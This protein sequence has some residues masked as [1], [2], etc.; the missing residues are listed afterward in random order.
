[1]SQ[2]VSAIFDIGKT[3]KKFFLFN[4]DFQVVLEESRLLPE[5]VDEDGES[6]EDLNTLLQWIMTT[7]NNALQLN[8]YNI[9]A[10][11]FSCYGASLIHLNGNAEPITP[12]YSYQKEMDEALLQQFYHN[13]GSKV[14]LWK[15]TG[16]D[17]SGFLNSGLQLY[18]LKHTKSNLF[19]KI[20]LSIHL[21]QYL[22][23]LFSGTAITE[24]TSLGCHTAMWDYQKQDYHAW[25]YEEDLVRL[26]P[27]ILDKHKAF[28]LEAENR[29]IKI[30]CGIHDSSAALL[31]YIL[32]QKKPFCLISTGT[33]SVS[34]N[35]FAD[36]MLTD[37]DINRNCIFYMQGDGKAVKSSRFMLGAEHDFQVKIL[38]EQYSV[39]AKSYQQL[40]F[41]S[42]VFDGVPK[43]DGCPFEWKYI[44]QTK[45]PPA[46]TFNSF[47]EAYHS[48]V[49]HLVRAQ[50]ESL[51]TLLESSDVSDIIVEGGFSSNQIFL[52]TLAECLSEHRIFSSQSRA[53]AALGAALSM[54]SDKMDASDLKSIYSLKEYK[55]KQDS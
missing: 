49:Y 41:S 35:P 46:Q 29:K 54:S 28:T 25:M 47:D 26:F 11:N 14:E 16:S 18:S 10:I 20:S 55:A 50:I 51:D 43:N 22:S 44:G 32:G 53:G 38:I 40:N 23:F 37:Q 31:P 36:A 33:W 1:M 2:N 12:L 42:E 21:P 34:F 24:F 8:E 13:Y 3:N 30:G 7:I 48:L 52:Q 17:L 9:E 19:E 5:S 15:Q 27:P 4:R 39:S 45:E 6:C